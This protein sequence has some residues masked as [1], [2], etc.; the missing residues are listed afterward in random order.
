MKFTQDWF[1][2]NIPNFETCMSALDKRELFMEIGSF[3]GRA[4]CWMLEN[5]LADDGEITCIDPYIKSDY[6]P[7]IDMEAVKDRFL[8]NTNE[9]KKPK[10]FVDL[11]EATSYTALSWLIQDI[12]GRADIYDF[13]Y[14]DGSHAPYDTLVD[15]CMAWGMLRKGGIMLFD[16]YMYPHEDTQTGIDAFLSALPYDKYKIL[17]TNYQLAVQK[18]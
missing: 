1:S 11:N 5:G 12:V 2:N 3:E 15:A 4:T 18:L 7:T 17:F 16:D 6:D 10:Q 8:S 14:V 13:I 9:V